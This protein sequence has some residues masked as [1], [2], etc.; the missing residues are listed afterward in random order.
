[1]RRRV[2]RGL[3]HRTAA[4]AQSFA[5][6]RAAVRRGKRVRRGLQRHTPR[7]KQ[8][9]FI[10]VAAVH[11]GLRRGAAVRRAVVAEIVYCCAVEL[12]AAA[13]LLG[14]PTSEHV[15]VARR[16]FERDAL[17]VFR[18]NIRHRV[19][20]LVAEVEFERVALLLPYGCQGVTVLRSVDG[21]RRN[22]IAVAVL[23]TDEFMT[24]LFR[25]QRRDLPA[26]YRKMAGE[27]PL[28]L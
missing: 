2:R 25:R 21:K 20:R 10:A 27:K 16:G 19:G 5:V 23:P 28:F 3:R 22:G 7:R 26:V 6:H 11:D 12:N 4:Q 9:S 13:V 17:A 24:E 8:L 1:M 15:A 18:G 14:E